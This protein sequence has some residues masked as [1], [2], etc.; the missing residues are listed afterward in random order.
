M[1]AAASRMMAAMTGV[2]AVI[3]T[4]LGWLGYRS[5]DME[6]TKSFNVGDVSSFAVRVDSGAFTVPTIL[7]ALRPSPKNCR[8]GASRCSVFQAISSATHS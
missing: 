3:T 7:E 6:V 1:A 5:L 2:L 4:A 8:C